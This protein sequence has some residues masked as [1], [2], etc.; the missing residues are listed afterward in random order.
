MDLNLRKF[1]VELYHYLDTKSIEVHQLDAFINYVDDN[2]K[3]QSGLLEGNLYW[4]I[5][6]KGKHKFR[7]SSVY[8]DCHT[9]HCC[10]EHGC[11][12]GDENCVVWLGYAEQSYTCESCSIYNKKHMEIPEIATK[13]YLER[14]DNYSNSW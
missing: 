14:R 8:K 3:V 13:I 5:P 11:K 12:Y 4:Q 1:L 6:T 7:D 9:E 2:K 10:C